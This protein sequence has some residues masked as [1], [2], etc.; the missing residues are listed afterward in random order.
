MIL[1]A[2]SPSAP[3]EGPSPPTRSPRSRSATRRW[4]RG[5][6]FAELLPS[7][8]SGFIFNDANDDGLLD[9]PDAGIAGVN[10]TFTGTNDLVHPVSLSTTTAIDG[11]YTFTGLRPGTYT[12]AEA[13]VAGELVGK[14]TVGVS[15]GNAGSQSIGGV[16]LPQGTADTGNNFAW[17]QPATLSG[18]VYNDVNDDGTFDG[19]DVGVGGVTVN[20][21]G[22]N[23]LGGSVQLSTITANDGS[24]SFANLRP[25]PTR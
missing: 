15:G 25:G 17:L 14:T 20:L 18:F 8:L 11:S 19:A 24:Y 23:D 13:S 9:G 12:V 6:D 16:A 5:N 10:L 21:T 3:P 1:T 2:R 22:T 4:T 7:S